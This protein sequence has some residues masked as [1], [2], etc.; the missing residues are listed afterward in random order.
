MGKVLPALTGLALG[1]ATAC[2]GSSDNDSSSGGAGGTGATSGSGGAAASG[3]TGGSSGSASGGSAGSGGQVQDAGTI[4]YRACGL[5]TGAI[6]F[7]ITKTDNGQGTCTAVV[8]VYQ[9]GTPDP[10]VQM[11]KDW[12]LESATI[13]NDATNCNPTGPAP[14][15]KVSATDA[16]GS[17]TWTPSASPFDFPK[18]V[19]IDLELSF[20]ATAPWVPAKDI[21]KATD[22]KFDGC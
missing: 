12:T 3:A 21:L 20:P 5:A 13:T 11:P 9:G 6:R 18:S 8:V 16:S 1:L 4:V 19:D 7:A 10:K 17:I 22:L 15:T 2:G 14:A